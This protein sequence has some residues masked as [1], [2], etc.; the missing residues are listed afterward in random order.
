MDSLEALGDRLRVG[1][2]V[3]VLAWAPLGPWLVPAMGLG[4][5]VGVAVLGKGTVLPLVGP[6]VVL[7]GAR[8]A[9]LEVKRASWRVV[10]GRLLRVA[11][12]GLLVALVLVGPFWNRNREV[13]GSVGGW[14]FFTYRRSRGRRRGAL[15]D[16]GTRRPATTD[17][18]GDMP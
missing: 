4:V 15:I 1:L 16:L 11:V 18:E 10:A 2:V 14:V 17:T 9:W 8:V 7:L 12:V 13:F 3:V 6:A 5:T